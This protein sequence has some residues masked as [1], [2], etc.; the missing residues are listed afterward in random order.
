MLFQI[1]MFQIKFIP[2]P[3]TRVI[4]DPIMEN[5]IR[6]KF[7]FVFKRPSIQTIQ[8]K[9]EREKERKRERKIISF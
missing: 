8:R 5:K 1:V 3:I 6:N 9:R 2:W 4:V 7:K